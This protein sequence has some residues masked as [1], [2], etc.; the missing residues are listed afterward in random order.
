MK[1][2]YSIIK[3]VSNSLSND[4]VGV[5]MVM[6]DEEKFF[7]K[8]S[9]QKIKIAKNLLGESNNF[10]DFFLSQIKNTIQK[11]NKDSESELFNNSKFINSEYIHYLH[12]YSNNIIQYQ[13]PKFI[14]EQN[15]IENFNNLFELLIDKN[16][17][18]KIAKPKPDTYLKAKK[19]IE[20]KLILRVKNKV[21]TNIK[22]TN[23]ILPSL[24]FNYEMDCIGLNGVF[25]GAKSLNF[26]QSEQTIQKELSNYFALSNIL[27]NTHNKYGA[28]NN[29]YLISEEPK[30]GNSKEHQ[31]W[32]K[33]SY[34]KRFKLIQPEE[35]EKVA[36]KIEETKAGIF[37]DL[38]N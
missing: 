27:E 35:S 9:D 30:N 29:F 5:G 22:F 11:I 8:F 21:H 33:I 36:I 1:T 20:K 37:L 25:T 4:S 17:Y 26:N 18:K 15:N 13:E 7:I 32:E 24:Y 12:K 3:V 10:I 34:L 28:K 16:M 6:S 31:L 19:I 38:K 2:Y 14:A 23:K